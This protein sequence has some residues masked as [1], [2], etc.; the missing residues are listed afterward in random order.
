MQHANDN[1]RYKPELAHSAPRAFAASELTSA[2][3][4]QMS[5]TD[6]L[7]ASRSISAAIDAARATEAA[8]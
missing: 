3:L 5:T 4:K 6:L 1:R 8:R 2:T 7:A